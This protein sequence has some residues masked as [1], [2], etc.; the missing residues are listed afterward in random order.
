MTG[1][2]VVAQGDPSQANSTI[3]VAKTFCLVAG[4]TYTFTYDWISYGINPLAA[5]QSTYIVAGTSPVGTSGAQL[6]NTIDAPPHSPNGSGHVVLTYTA[7][8]TGQYTFYFYWTFQTAGN[9]SGSRCYSG[10]PIV[11]NCQTYA[12]DFA[13]GQVVVNCS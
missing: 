4:K 12:N 13:V 10:G 11:S 3:T 1:P 6:G 7:P 5:H 8:T 2:V 9:Y